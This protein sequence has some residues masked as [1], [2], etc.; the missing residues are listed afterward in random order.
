MGRAKEKKAEVTGAVTATASEQA[1]ER[2]LRPNQGFFTVFM[3]GEAGHVNNA[4]NLRAAYS[5]CTALLFLLPVLG[6]NPPYR[7]ATVPID[8]IRYDAPGGP[9]QE[10]MVFLP[11]YGDT[12]SAVERH[13][14]VRAVWARGLAADIV[15]VDAHLGYYQDGTILTR[16]KEDV[17]NTAKAGGYK[18]IWLVGTSLGAYGAILYAGHY[19]QD[20]TGVVL[21]GPFLGEKKTVDEIRQ[22]GG[23]QQW[24]PGEVGNKTKEDWE[25]QI[26][27]WLK[28][29]QK[30]GDFRLWSK[31]CEQ[32]KGCL[33]KIYLGYGKLDRFS[34]GQDLLASVLPPEYVVALFGGHDWM[35]WKRAWDTV[36][37]RMTVTTSG[38]R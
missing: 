23:L 10:L 6:C 11:G 27:L 33:P 32:E 31:D 36:L 12:P 22:A 19:P 26:W 34:R 2:L 8:T 35:T 16:L 3:R 4:M 5:V 24:D 37:D 9:H 25:K 14:L 21:L 29:R 7:P 17:I 13:G 1:S 20:I 15:A 18:N 30:Q 38:G 28:L